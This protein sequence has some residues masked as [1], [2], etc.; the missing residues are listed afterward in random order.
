MAKGTIT[1]DVD[2]SRLN[3]YQE[4]ILDTRGALSFS[5]DSVPSYTKD[6]DFTKSFKLLTDEG[7]Y[8]YSPEDVEITYI[9]S[10]NNYTIKG[11]VLYEFSPGG[12]S[13]EDGYS[14]SFWA[15]GDAQA[16]LGRLLFC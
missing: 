1:Y 11:G 6:I 3:Y 14:S 9:N 4:D 12:G 8:F 10:K 13:G 16:I 5:R 7:Y 2:I 15:I